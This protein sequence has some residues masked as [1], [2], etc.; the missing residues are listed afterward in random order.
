MG[1]KDL[2]LVQSPD[3]SRLLVASY[4]SLTLE[5][6]LSNFLISE[7]DEGTECVLSMLADDTKLAGAIDTWEVR[8]TIERD[9]NILREWA[10]M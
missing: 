3:G 10:D 6:I 7:L 1:L 2:C 5:Q 9:L 8:E 4:Q